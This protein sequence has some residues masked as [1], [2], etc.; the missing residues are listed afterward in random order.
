MNLSLKKFYLIISAVT[1]IPAA[2]WAI[3][4]YN[5]HSVNTAL[6]NFVSFYVEIA[7]LTIVTRYIFCAWM[8]KHL[9]RRQRFELTGAVVT[10]CMLGLIVD[11]WSAI[12]ITRG[13]ALPPAEN[14]TILYPIFAFIGGL[15]L[16]VIGAL[17]GGY[18]GGLGEPM[19]RK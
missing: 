18:V 17:V 11:S 7:Q 19:R 5:T 15:P 12:N 1:V 13:V 16:M 8:S 10:F 14:W 4:A 2:V 6:A 9:A 3:A